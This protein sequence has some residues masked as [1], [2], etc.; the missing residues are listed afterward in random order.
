MGHTDF[1]YIGLS[2]RPRSGSAL[3]FCNVLP[4]GTPDVR[5]CHRA[6]P[7]PAGMAKFGCNIW[8]DDVTMQAHALAKPRSRPRPSSGCKGGGL[9]APLLQADPEDTPPP[10]PKAL[11]GL[12][13]RRTFDGLG[14]FVGV[15]SS[16]DPTLF[17]L[18]VCYDDGDEEDLGVE[19]LLSLPLAAPAELVGRRVSKHFPGHGRFDGVIASHC[20]EKGFRVT[21]DDGDSEDVWE[22]E[23]VRLL[24]LEQSAGAE[25]APSRARPDAVAKR[26]R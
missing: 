13:V 12:K 22:A 3:L 23:G 17:S 11:I 2:V 7:V 19:R 1:P 21:Y 20:A 8:I 26:K 14:D 4:D 15:V 16:Y 9:L 6:C 18:R 24:Q 25:R 10:Q 5:M